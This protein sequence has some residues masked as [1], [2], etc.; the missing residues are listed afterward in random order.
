MAVL[1][2][3]EH[4][5]AP[6]QGRDAEHRHG[7][8]GLRRRGARA[9]RRPQR[10][11]R[12]CRPRRR[13]PASPRCC[14]PTPRASPTAW[15]R[16]WPR[17][18]SAIASGYSH[19]LFPATAA[20]KNVAPRVAALLDVG[21]DQRSQQGDQRRHLRAPDLCRQRDRHGAEQRCHQGDHRAHDRLRCRGR[22]RRQRRG[23]DDRRGGRCG[24]S[25]A[26]SAARSPRTTGP[27]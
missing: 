20:G 4:D 22:H 23:R 8:A 6:C 14:M 15:P 16:T 10:R 1:V 18:S 3:A 7:R 12:R 27:S 26:S 21:A 13:S 24:Q 9:G 25:A 2:I 17:R 19:L 5:N 11:W